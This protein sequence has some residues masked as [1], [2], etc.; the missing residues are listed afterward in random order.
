MM[1]KIGC[2]VALATALILTSLPAALGEVNFGHFI[3]KFVA[4]FGD[5]GRKVTLM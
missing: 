5:D 2:S 3:G 1:M 4:E